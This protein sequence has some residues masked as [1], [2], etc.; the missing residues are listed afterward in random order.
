M[1]EA[2]RILLADD[3]PLLRDGVVRSLE[4]ESGWRVVAQ[5]ECC[6]QA[7]AMARREQPDVALVDLS[8]PGIG[9]IE[10]IR[11]VAS[12][13]PRTR[14]VVLT[15]SSDSDELFAALKA[16]AHAYVLKGVSA[17]ELREAVRRVAAGESY[18][19]PALAG[20]LLV[21]LTRAKAGPMNLLTG[22]EAEVLGHLAQGRTN[23]EIGERL[24]LAEKTV[25]HHVTQLLAKLHVRSRTEAALLAQREGRPGSE[26]ARIGR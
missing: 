9:G 11:Q 2:L 17:F 1:P 22:R 20:H 8:M 13:C 23:R 19:P 15:A 16:G 21:E 10:V 7:V 18:V 3:H 26:R 6:D 25:K 5:A 24:H 4:V 12:S 14:I